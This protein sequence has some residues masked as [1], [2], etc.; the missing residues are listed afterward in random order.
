MTARGLF[1]S[2]PEVVIDPAVPV[3]RWHLSPEGIARLRRLVI[4]TAPAAVWASDETK[5]IESAGILAARFGLPVQ[6][7]RGLAEMDRS[8]TG[9]RPRAAFERL[10]DAFFA[11]PEE[12]IEGW[13]RAVDAQRRVVAAAQEILSGH[14]GGDII[15]VGHGGTGALLMCALAGLPITRAHDQPAAGCCWRFTLQPLR[16]TEAWQPFG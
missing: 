1:V 3:P 2:H 10:A 16:V 13:E 4:D 14:G 8:S 7:H 15:M 9:Y 6:V 12:S 11:R 5:A